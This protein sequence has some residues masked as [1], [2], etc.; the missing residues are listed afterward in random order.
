[1][2]IFKAINLIIAFMVLLASCHKETSTLSSNTE[3]SEYFPNKAGDKWM[4]NVYD[5]VA[6]K[7]EEVSVEI[8]GTKTLPTGEIANV[9]MYKYTNK[10]DSN[11]VFQA[12]DTVKIIRDSDLNGT[13]Y[14]IRKK[15]IIPLFVGNSWI[16][17]YIFDYFNDSIHVISETSLRVNNLEFDSTYFLTELGETNSMPF[18]YINAEEYFQPKIGF[19]RM[20]EYEAEEYYPL[21]NKVWYL[22][23]YHLK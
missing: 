8:T 1:M 23:E 5:S 18:D 14:L 6:S 13:N 16:N 19:V 22:K 7:M 10:T 15:Y 9:W 17:Q 20:H 21:Q 4:Y 11:F 12:G 3:A 2:K